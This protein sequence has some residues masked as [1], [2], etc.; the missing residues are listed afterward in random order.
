M[1]YKDTLIIILQRLNQGSKY[2]GY[3]I[4]LS[5][6]QNLSSVMMDKSWQKEKREKVR[7]SIL[8]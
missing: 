3:G 6:G 4:G 7:N 1:K 8:H 2:E 5:T